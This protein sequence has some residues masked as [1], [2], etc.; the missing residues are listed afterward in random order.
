MPF[1]LCSIFFDRENF[2]NFFGANR[3]IIIANKT[4]YQTQMN[5]ILIFGSPKPMKIP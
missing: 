4:F 5:V 2:L 1:L 3:K